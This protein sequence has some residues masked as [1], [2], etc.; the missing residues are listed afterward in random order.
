MT[1]ER[2]KKSLPKRISKF[3][4]HAN[5]GGERSTETISNENK[6]SQKIGEVSEIERLCLPVGVKEVI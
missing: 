1:R 3:F 4:V 2:K 6:R 5:K